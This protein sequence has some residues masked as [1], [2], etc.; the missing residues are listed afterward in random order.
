MLIHNG[1][2]GALTGFWTAKFLTHLVGHGIIAGVTA[3]VAIVCPP[4]AYTVGVSLEYTFGPVIEATSNVMG[5]AGG[6]AGG[7]V[8]GPV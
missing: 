2:G 4:A 6:I 3:G 5:L 8:T 1:V 7:T